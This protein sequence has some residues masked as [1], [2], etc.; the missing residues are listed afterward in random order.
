MKEALGVAFLSLGVIAAAVAAVSAVG[1]L[2]SFYWVIV[3]PGG[4]WSKTGEFG[5]SQFLLSFLL[6]VGLGGLAFF[7]IASARRLLARK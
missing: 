3:D 5:R 4:D 7:L 6:S 1:F 2:S